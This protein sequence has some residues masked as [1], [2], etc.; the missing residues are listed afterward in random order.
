MRDGS[1]EKKKKCFYIS[2]SLFFDCRLEKLLLLVVVV[3]EVMVVVVVVVAVVVA[4][5]GLVG[6]LRQPRWTGH[7]KRGK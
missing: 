3:A 2:V 5:V 1:L 6:G 7:R 4:V